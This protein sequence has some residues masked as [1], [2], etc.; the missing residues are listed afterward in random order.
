MLKLLILSKT[1]NPTDCF[2]ANDAQ[3]IKMIN[4]VLISPIVYTMLVK[5]VC[6]KFH[7]LILSTIWK[8]KYN[9]Y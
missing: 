3:V 4:D 2:D 7:Q 5:I 9:K 6:S 8:K 1:L